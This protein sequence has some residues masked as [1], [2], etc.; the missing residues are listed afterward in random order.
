MVIKTYYP[1]VSKPFDEYSKYFDILSKERREKVMRLHSE[2]S[3]I[4]SVMTAVFTRECIEKITGIK[5]AEQKFTVNE[6]GKPALADVEGFHF[7]VSH[8]CG[9][10]AFVHSNKPVGIDVERINGFDSR[11]PKRFFTDNE[12]IMLDNAPEKEIEFFRIWT[13]KESYIK[14]KGSTLSQMIRHVD[15]YNIRDAAINTITEKGYIIT[16][17]EQQYN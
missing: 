2:Q 14:M 10:I 15:I 16:A 12:R 11:L 9:C 3:K 5:A 7:N 13:L 1:D 17:C 4:I 6:N 8:S